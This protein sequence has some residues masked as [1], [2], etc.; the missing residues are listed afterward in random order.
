[1]SWEG[2]ANRMERERNE[3]QERS[4]WLESCLGGAERKISRLEAELAQTRAQLRAASLDEVATHEELAKART[5]LDRVERLRHWRIIDGDV[6]ELARAL[7]RALE[8]RE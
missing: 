2:R 4:T 7:I 6:S 1:M 8:G 3:A 5:R